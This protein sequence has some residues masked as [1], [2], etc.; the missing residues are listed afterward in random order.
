M[1]LQG[2]CREKIDLLIEFQRQISTCSDWPNH[3]L[4]GTYGFVLMSRIYRLVLPIFFDT[5]F[6]KNRTSRAEPSFLLKIRAEPSL[7]PS[8][9]QAQGQPQYLYI[10]ARALRALASSS[11]WAA[12][13]GATRGPTQGIDPRSQGV[14]P[15]RFKQ[16]K[17]FVTYAR[18]HERTYGRTDVTVEIGGLDLVKIWQF[19]IYIFIYFSIQIFEYPNIQYLS[20]WIF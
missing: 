9:A 1:A 17:N 19:W 5:S 14:I 8:R 10:L 18:T 6:L 15:R 2:Y 20:F 13:P 4:K 3:I 7:N 12:C 11:G 16:K